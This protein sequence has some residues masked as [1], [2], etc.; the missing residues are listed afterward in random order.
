MIPD[1]QEAVQEELATHLAMTVSEYRKTDVLNGA[2]HNANMVWCERG[3]DSHE[4]LSRSD[5]PSIRFDSSIRLEH[6]PVTLEVTGSIPVRGATMP[7]SP[8]SGDA[9]S[10]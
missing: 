7:H 1:G 9:V 6:Q 8:I 5:F 10:A 2:D 3:L 4:L